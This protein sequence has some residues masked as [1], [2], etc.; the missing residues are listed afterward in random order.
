M[1][2]STVCF[3]VISLRFSTVAPRL[4]S[5]SRS[6]PN[7]YSTVIEISLSKSAVKIMIPRRHSRRGSSQLSP[8]SPFPPESGDFLVAGRQ[9]TSMSAVETAGGLGRSLCRMTPLCLV[10][11]EPMKEQGRTFQ[12]GPCRQIIVFFKVSDAS[13]YIHPA[14][15]VSAKPR[16]V[17]CCEGFRMPGAFTASPL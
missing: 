1:A 3:V 17:A 7:R 16:D 13:P 6:N 8:L 12:C 15:G 11:K 9:V 4:R 5:V 10:C 2:S 14:R